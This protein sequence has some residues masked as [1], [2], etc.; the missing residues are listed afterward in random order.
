MFNVQQDCNQSNESCKKL[1]ANVDDNMEIKKIV[2]FSCD[3]SLR[4]VTA[5]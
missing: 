2:S 4:S 3:V 5:V 1:I